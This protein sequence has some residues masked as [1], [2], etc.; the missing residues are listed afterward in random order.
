ML[1]TDIID[2]I[3]SFMEGH[4]RADF[5]SKI[6]VKLKNKNILINQLDYNYFHDIRNTIYLTYPKHNDNLIGYILKIVDGT[7]INYQWIKIKHTYL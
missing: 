2:I 6:S 3:F 4:I 7:R 5:G 1:S